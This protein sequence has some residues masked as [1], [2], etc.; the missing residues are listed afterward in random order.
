MTLQYF[1]DKEQYMCE[2]MTEQITINSGNVSKRYFGSVELVENRV[3]ATSVSLQSHYNPNVYRAVVIKAVFLPDVGK[4]S[5][6]LVVCGIRLAK[7]PF[8]Q[9]QFL[10]DFCLTDRS[11]QYTLTLSYSQLE[12]ARKDSLVQISKTTQSR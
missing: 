5:L 4:L 3:M 7:C 6:W 2:G 8:L 12:E 1:L 10:L 11:I 9:E